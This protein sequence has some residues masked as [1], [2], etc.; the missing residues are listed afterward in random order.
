MVNQEFEGLTIND[1]S[2]PSCANWVH[3]VQYV[4]PQVSFCADQLSFSPE[5]SG[6]S[7]KGQEMSKLTG[8]EDNFAHLV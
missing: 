2:D 3:H 8:C 4:L 5:V 6:V 1:M 7:L